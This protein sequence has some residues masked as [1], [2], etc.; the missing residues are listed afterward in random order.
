M[1]SPEILANTLLENRPTSQILNFIH[2]SRYCI[3]L[4]PIFSGVRMLVHCLCNYDGHPM[5]S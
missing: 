5:M 1:T 2:S 4:L 3:S